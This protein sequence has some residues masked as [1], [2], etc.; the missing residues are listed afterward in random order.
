[1]LNKFMNRPLFNNKWRIAI[2]YGLIGVML[3]RCINNPWVT[4][5]NPEGLTGFPGYAVLFLSCG[6]CAWISNREI[7]WLNEI[8]RSQKLVD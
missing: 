6:I 8:Q 3:N 2:W 4:D 5:T 1:M 7:A